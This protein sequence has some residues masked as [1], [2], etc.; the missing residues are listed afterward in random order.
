MGFSYL[1]TTT[2]GIY[3]GDINFEYLNKSFWILSI[4]STFNPLIGLE[5]FPFSSFI[6][7][8]IYPPPQL[9]ISLAKAEIVLIILSGLK[10]SLNSILADSTTF[11][12]NSFQL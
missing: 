11:S 9:S 3:E 5:I 4:S 8:A 12:F 7:I 10:F 1:T 2:I 6:P